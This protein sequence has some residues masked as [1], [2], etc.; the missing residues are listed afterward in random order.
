MGVDEW[1]LERGD[2]CNVLEVTKWL[3]GGVFETSRLNRGD[4][5]LQELPPCDP[6]G[7]QCDR[8]ETIWCD[9][10]PPPCDD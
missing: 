6:P 9:E 3:N 2:S 4:L 7:S 1:T 10:P 8:C 5:C